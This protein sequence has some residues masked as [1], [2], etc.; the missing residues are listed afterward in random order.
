MKLTGINTYNS[1]IFMY[2]KS[3][4]TYIYKSYF[5]CIFYKPFDLDSICRFYKTLS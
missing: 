3:I 5:Y 2:D 1:D 4:I